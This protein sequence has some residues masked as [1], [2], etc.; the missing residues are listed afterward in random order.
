MACILR[1]I[2]TFL[3][4]AAM[5]HPQIA[6]ATDIPQDQNIQSAAPISFQDPAHSH[7]FKYQAF[8]VAQ[9]KPA[10]TAE[11]WR[12]L[13]G[14]QRAQKVAAGESFL[15]KLHEKFSAKN[16]LSPDEALIFEA[17]WGQDAARISPNGAPAGDASK[18]QEAA[19]LKVGELSKSIEPNGSP[20]RWAVL[21]DGDASR[22]ITND[23]R[24]V[25]ASPPPIV[26]RDASDAARKPS[27][28]AASRAL[29]SQP[30]SLPRDASDR[31]NSNSPGLTAFA[32]GLT[33][34]GLGALMLNMKRGMP[35]SENGNLST[36]DSLHARVAKALDAKSANG[37]SAEVQPTGATTACDSCSGNCSGGC[38][39][40]C[41]GQC[42]GCTGDCSGSCKGDCTVGCTGGCFGNCKGACALHKSASSPSQQANRD[43]GQDI[44]KTLAARGYPR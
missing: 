5:S 30:L 20:S 25:A 19:A 31:T 42:G 22:S 43:D 26:S 13:P 23:P 32:I 14:P 41:K 8:L 11:T 35:S 33:M 3:L 21:F 15:K 18:K 37:S 17:V 7:F 28:T 36:I 34:L 44:L 6:G 40:G 39:G 4:A 27:K 9:G 10:E 29:D 24:L 12:A 1:M 16:A 2:A 38:W